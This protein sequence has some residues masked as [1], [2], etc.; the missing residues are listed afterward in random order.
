MLG[1]TAED[2][3]SKGAHAVQRGSKEGSKEGSYQ[4]ALIDFRP[5]QGHGDAVEENEGQNHIVK[6]LV[7]D[8]GTTQLTEPGE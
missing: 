1:H 3:A 6:Q 5:L 4:A 2:P 7:N 8:D